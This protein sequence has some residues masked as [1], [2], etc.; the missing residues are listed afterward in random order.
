GIKRPSK[1]ELVTRRN[2]RKSIIANAD[3]KKGT[4]I[5]RNMLSIKRPG[6]GIEPKYFEQVV[7]RVAVEDI[8]AEE[9]VYWN[10]V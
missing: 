6:M 8:P 9:P 3:I 7:G 10:Y 2:N 5:T 1:D 4:L